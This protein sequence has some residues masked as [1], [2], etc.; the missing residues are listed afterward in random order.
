M[1]HIFNQR[2]R[3]WKTQNRTDESRQ[4]EKR[5]MSHF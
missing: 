5:D 2:S 1:F 3:E 4:M